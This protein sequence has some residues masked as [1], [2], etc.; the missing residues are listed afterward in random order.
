[1]KK[2]FILLLA[3]IMCF[4]LVAC[5]SK[6]LTLENLSNMYVDGTDDARASFT[7]AD[8]TMTIEII[9]YV[10]SS[11]SPSGKIAGNREE[12]TK[13]YTLDGEN[14]IT[15]DGIQ[16]YYEIDEENK[17]VEFSTKFMNL[18]KTFYFGYVQ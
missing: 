15:V 11:S 13:E 16:Y 6:T 9:Y 10:E 17:T 2:L 8:G 12:Y 7:F 14:Y 3:I 5:G 18:S 4:S 1:M